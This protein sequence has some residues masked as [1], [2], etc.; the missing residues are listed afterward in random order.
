MA[1]EVRAEA[2]RAR[3]RMVS[4]FCMA[5]ISACAVVAA[6][7]YAAKGGVSPMEL[8]QA[9]K[10]GAGQLKFQALQGN[11]TAPADEAPPSEAEGATEVASDASAGGDGKSMLFVQDGSLAGLI[12]ADIIIYLCGAVSIP[13][14][15]GIFWLGRRGRCSGDGVWVNIPY[16]SL[17]LQSTGNEKAFWCRRGL[18][19]TCACLVYIDKGGVGT[20]CCSCVSHTGCGMGCAGAAKGC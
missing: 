11:E 8:L 12:A 9:S 2:A 16:Q 6:F 19:H 20:M 7:D 18:E 4:G 15:A 10:V 1:A 14:R 3:A 5:V 17:D 13:W